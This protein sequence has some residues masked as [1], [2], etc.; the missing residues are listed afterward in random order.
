MTFASFN[1]QEGSNLWGMYWRY[2][3]SISLLL[4][5]VAFLSEQVNL[6]NVGNNSGLRPTIFW[7]IIAGLFIS[8]TLFKI[9]GLAYVFLGNRL[10]LTDKTWSWFNCLTISLFVV[11]AI[12]G[13]VVSQ[14]AS[15]EVWALYKLFGQPLCLVLLP[16]FSSC[17]VVRRVKTIS[18]LK[19][20]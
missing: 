2:I 18:H 4:V 11:L 19:V 5:L 20:Q 17:F 14:I 10:Q 8:V 7:S 9:K 16:W 15:K 3:L 1:Q 13:Y 6:I 12:I